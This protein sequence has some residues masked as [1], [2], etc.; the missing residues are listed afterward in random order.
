MELVISSPPKDSRETKS[1]NIRLRIDRSKQSSNMIISGIWSFVQTLRFSLN[2]VL[3]LLFP[4]KVFDYYMPEQY[5]NIDCAQISHFVWDLWKLKKA[6]YMK[7]Y[8][9]S[10]FTGN[11]YLI[12]T[13]AYVVVQVKIPIGDGSMWY[14]QALRFS[15]TLSKITELSSYHSIC[16]CCVQRPT[17]VIYSTIGTC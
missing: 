7:G 13:K 10:S 5:D 12:W 9:P 1:R 11:K 15:K 17:T 6:V 16:V 2:M 3:Y 14:V 4:S 8:L